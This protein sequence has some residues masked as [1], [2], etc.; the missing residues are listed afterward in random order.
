MRLQ[1]DSQQKGQAH[2]DD[3]GAEEIGAAVRH[4]VAMKHRTSPE[5]AFTVIDG[6]HARD[7][8]PVV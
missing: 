7:Y 1:G 2:H 6:K 3:Q 4:S 5:H 8:S